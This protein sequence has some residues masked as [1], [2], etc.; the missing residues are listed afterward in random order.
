[1]VKNSIDD[2]NH[3]N[4]DL[5]YTYTE[6][7]LKAVNDDVNTINTKLGTVI[8]F[9]GVLVKVAIDLPDQKS[10]ISG[11]NCYTC[12]VIKISICTLLL[13]SIW[14]ST[15]ALIPIVNSSIAKP[16]ELL[17]NWYTVDSEVCRLFILKGLS[18]AIEGLDE[19][20]ER[21]SN[22]LSNGI[23][24]IAGAFTLIVMGS[25]LISIL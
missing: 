20:R 24:L 11:L 22:Q 17:K 21:K 2:S 15:S 10:I 14:I 12:L 9:N 8:A 16:S 7:I 13:C 3:N 6:S 19:E 1:M 5:I 25:L 18:Q 4:L 23:R